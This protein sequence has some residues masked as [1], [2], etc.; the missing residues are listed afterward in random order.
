VS[1]ST[2]PHFLAN[3]DNNRIPFDRALDFAN[4]ERITELLYPLFVHNIGALLYHP[5]NQA[6]QGS[7][8]GA[9]MAARRPEQQPD[10]MRTPTSSQP[11]AL[12]HHHSMS[13][14]S[15][16]QPPHSMAPH[17]ASGRPGLDRAHTFP[18]PPTSASSVTMNMGQSGSSYDYGGGQ[19]AAMQSG[20]HIPVHSVV[21]RSMPTSPPASTSP[22]SSAQMQYPTTQAYDGARPMYSAQGPAYPQYS[23]P[24][25][26]HIQPSPGVKTEMAPPA[27]AGADNEHAEHKPHDAYSSQHDGDGEHE[28]E[29]THTSA[30]YGGRKASYAGLPN[31]SMG[32]MHSDSSHISPEMTHSP[33]QNG[34]GRA[35]P[36][37]TATYPG[38]STP[39]RSQ[40]PASNLYN[41]ISNDA[42]AGAP[43]GNDGYHAQGYQTQYPSMNGVPPSNKR[44]REIDDEDQYGRPLSSN[45]IKRARTDTGSVSGVRPISQQQP[46]KPIR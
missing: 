23:T 18:T 6:R 21:S 36:R 41:V 37:T 24:Q 20:Q 46:V 22:G 42:R 45:D 10:Y 16:T 4:K 14:P 17:P 15:V 34:S 5:T 43:N 27:R 11:P 38:Y 8:S 12:T 29:Y 33:H 13:N 31:A 30:A 2:E 25:Y 1:F 7:M 32:Q 40:L 9:A 26:G 39:Q 28:G 19:A 44:G 3:T 35:T